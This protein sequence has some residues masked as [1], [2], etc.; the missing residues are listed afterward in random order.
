VPNQVPTTPAGLRC[1]LTQCD[2]TTRL[3]CRSATYRYFARQNQQAWHARGQGFESPKLH[4]FSCLFSMKKCLSI[5]TWEEVYSPQ[6]SALRAVPTCVSCKRRGSGRPV[7]R[8]SP[9]TRHGFFG[10]SS[11][12]VGDQVSER[13]PYRAVGL[14]WLHASA[15]S[16]AVSRGRPCQRLSRRS[17]LLA[18]WAGTLFVCRLTAELVGGQIAAAP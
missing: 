7:S 5:D 15:K 8:A 10:G 11:R 6:S 1:R 3:S 16:P 18:R 13:G 9:Q 14:N 12:L 17:G 2:S 4:D